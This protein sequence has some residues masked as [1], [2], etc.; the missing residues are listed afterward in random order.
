MTYEQALQI[1]D[2][3]LSQ[4]KLNR[5]EHEMLAQALEIVKKQCQKPE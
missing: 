1:L 2:Q 4:L 3:A 5:Q